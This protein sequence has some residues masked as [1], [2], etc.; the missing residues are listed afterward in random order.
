MMQSD[1]YRIRY[2]GRVSAPGPFTK[3]LAVVAGVSVLVIGLMFSVVLVGVALVVGSIAGGW[4]WWKT[5]AL[6]RDLREQMARMQGDMDA[7]MNRVDRG[8]QGH[9]A[10][11]GSVIDGDFIRERPEARPPGRD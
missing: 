1:P 8:R 5:R 6:R 11:P 7:A 2:S 3:A 4:L 10:D 9:A